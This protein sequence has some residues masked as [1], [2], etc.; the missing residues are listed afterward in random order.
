MPE[1]PILIK[2][3]GNRRLYDTR[4][5]RHVTLEDLAALV[6][7][8]AEVKVV[9]AKGGGDLT[10]QVLT[11]VILEQQERLDLIPV[12]LLHAV[13]RVQGTVQQAPLSAFLAAAARQLGA[14]GELWLRQLGLLAS[15]PSPADSG[16]AT[17]AGP[18][19]LDG[20]R[21]RMDALLKRLDRK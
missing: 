20:L 3:Y 1:E 12:E 6:R 5:S 8:G 16:D 18:S 15:P 14:A 4:H 19:E 13:I 7:G 2:K 9:D 10:R 21:A 11:Q 17:Q